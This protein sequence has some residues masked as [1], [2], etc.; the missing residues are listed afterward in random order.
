MSSNASSVYEP[1]FSCFKIFDPASLTSGED[2]A[3]AVA[4]LEGALDDR[5]TAPIIRF[6]LQ[7]ERPHAFEFMISCMSKLLVRY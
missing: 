7:P 4:V 3:T 5:S 6:S 2:I 1:I